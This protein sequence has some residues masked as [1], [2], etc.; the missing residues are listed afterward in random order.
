ML[1]F[2]EPKIDEKLKSATSFED[3]MEKVKEEDIR[4]SEE[5]RNPQI[6]VNEDEEV[7][8]D[9]DEEPEYLSKIVEQSLEDYNNT[10]L[11]DINMKLMKAGIGS[12]L[13]DD[14]EQMDKLYNLLT[15]EEKKTFTK[16]AEA[17]HYDEVGISK[18][19][20]GKKN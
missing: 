14:D 10:D 1:L 9:S 12:L 8:F 13:G 4:K 6:E 18:S 16:L 7:L 5:E 2:Q 11:E 15:D 19:C 3:Y 20:F 17:I